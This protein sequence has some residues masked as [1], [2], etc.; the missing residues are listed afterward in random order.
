MFYEA[1]AQQLFQYINHCFQS[2]SYTK[3]Y[4]LIFELLQSINLSD[5]LWLD[6]LR[7][8][9]SRQLQYKQE[10]FKIIQLIQQQAIA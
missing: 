10:I 6:A 2:Q 5:P 3:G 9:D 1:I 4:S 7:K 8:M